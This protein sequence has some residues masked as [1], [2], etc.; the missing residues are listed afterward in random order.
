[1]LMLCISFFCTF[2]SVGI[3]T[4]GVLA[5]RKLVEVKHVFTIVA[6]F[7]TMGFCIFLVLVCFTV[8]RQLVFDT[9]T[10]PDPI[11]CPECGAMIEEAINES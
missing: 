2:I 6:S 11:S 3:M 10:E 8:G 7:I 1:M 5:V 4:G 9:S